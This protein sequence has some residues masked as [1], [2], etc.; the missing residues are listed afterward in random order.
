MP[1]GRRAGSAI[2]ASFVLLPCGASSHSL[3][4]ATSS[5]TAG[6]PP[7]AAGAD[8]GKPAKTTYRV[9]RASSPIVVDGR[10]NEGTWEKALHLRLPYEVN[11]GDNVPSQVETEAYLAYDETHLY[12]AFRARDPNISAIHARLSDR[13]L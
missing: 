10:L 2:L 7:A 8:P 13:D 5:E 4:S 12:A 9:P 3:A 6:A 11:P 1:F